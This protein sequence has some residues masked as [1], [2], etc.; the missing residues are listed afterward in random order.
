MSKKKKL[1]YKRYVFLMM[2]VCLICVLHKND[3]TVKGEQK[4]TLEDIQEM[5]MTKEQFELVE[6]YKPPKMHLKAVTKNKYDSDYGFSLLSVSEKEVY[7][8][9][10]MACAQF[11]NSNMNAQNIEDENVAIGIELEDGELSKDRIAYVVVGFIYDH[12]Q[13]FWTK[14]YSY[15]VGQETDNVKKIV[16]QCDE[17]YLDGQKRYELWKKMEQKIQAYLDQIIGIKDDYSKELILHDALAKQLSYAYGNTGSAEKSK[18]AHNIEGAFSE[19][20]NKVVCEGYA[21]AFQLLLNAAGIENIYIVGNG[22]TG[23]SWQGHAWNQVKIEEKWYLVDL[24][25]NDGAIISRKYFNLSQSAF[26]PTHVAFNQ[27]S[28]QVARW[29]YELEEADGMDYSYEQKGEYYKNNQCHQLTYLLPKQFDLKVYNQGV[30][31]QNNS[32][33]E[34]GTKLEY[35]LVAKEQNVVFDGILKIGS[36]SYK[37]KECSN[38]YQGSFVMGKQ[39]LQ[40][41]MYCS[42]YMPAEELLDYVT[43]PE[44]IVM[45][46][47][48]ITYLTLDKPKQLKKYHVEYSWNQ[49]NVV[50]IT[51]TGMIEGRNTGNAEVTMTITDNKQNIKV[52]Q[53]NITVE[54]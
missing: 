22:K 20:Y 37:L 16:L 11:Q 39:D 38:G 51:A 49:E 27:E 32:T 36:D 43:V 9:L 8:R 52:F 42:S 50:N 6:Y 10:E 24:T 47:G 48:Q 53:I 7:K 26:L 5:S 15:W 54:E 28:K 4:T 23:G 40:L 18:W 19:E 41:K 25:W 31:V 29:C 46:K 33:I 45:K 17:N 14:G 2:C 21:K 13:Y 1:L 35:E 34:E 12:P 3:I 30:E 44:H